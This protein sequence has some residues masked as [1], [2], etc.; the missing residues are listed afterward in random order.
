MK[1][2]ADVNAHGTPSPPI[3]KD[4][5]LYLGG[6]FVNGNFSKK[7][8]LPTYRPARR[9]LFRQGSGAGAVVS[10]CLRGVTKNA[11]VHDQVRV[12]Q[13]DFP[14]VLHGLSRHV[15]Y[16]RA[17]GDNKPQRMLAAQPRPRSTGR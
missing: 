9:H 3:C 8:D 5:F 16:T 2:W 10:V 7:R 6:T 11:D 17:A 4:I 1:I 12:E 14:D 15:L 13:I